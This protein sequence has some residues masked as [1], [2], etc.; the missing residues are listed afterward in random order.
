MCS[1]NVAI[2]HI[3]ESLRRLTILER[4]YTET[5]HQASLGIKAVIALLLNSILIPIIANE[6]IKE[7]NIYGVK[8]LA[9]DVF[10]LGITN[11]FLQPIMKVFD[12]YYYYTRIL[13]WW[14]N[15]SE[16]KLYLNQPDLNLYNEYIEFETGY[17]YIYIVNLFLFT[18]F[19]VSLQPII[20]VFALVGM[21]MMYWAQKY[22]VYSRTKRPVPGTTA[23]NTAMY[24]LI[25]MGPLFFS[26]GNFTWSH[27]L[28]EEQDYDADPA[29][30]IPNIISVAL[31]VIIFIL[32]YRLIFELIFDDEVEL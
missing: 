12:M 21:I 11:S 6:F 20:S 19:F 26:L 1:S 8:G 15:K 32:P 27:F 4:E 29:R 23:I 2:P 18:C 25:Y 9:Y 22:S 16:Q 13:A 3:I 24:Q 14:Y 17:E 30:L 31:S 10:L 5:N 7:K 28:T